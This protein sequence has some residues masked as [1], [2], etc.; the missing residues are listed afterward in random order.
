MNTSLVA[1]LLAVGNP[2]DAGRCFAVDVGAHHGE[3]ANF[4]TSTGVFGKVVSFEPNSE[5]YLKLLNGVSSTSTS[6]YKAIN[7][8]L[9]S[10]SETLDLYCDEDTATASLLKYERN[11]ASHGRIEKCTVSALTLDEYLD[12]NVGLG[13]LK[14]LKIDTQGND[15]SVIRG[16]ADDFR[17]SANYPNRV[18]LHS[19]V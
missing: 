3:Y 18:Y 9:S 11:Y 6:Q 4:L 8:A 7:S 19:V 2:E 16:A 12:A 5:S 17:T 14:F 10:K 13:R 1:L 15:L